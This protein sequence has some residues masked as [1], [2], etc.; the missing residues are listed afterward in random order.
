MAHLLAAQ[1]IWLQRCKKQPAAGDALWPDWKA[2]T[3]KK[4]IEDNHAAWIGFLEDLKDNDFAESIIYKNSKGQTFT[5]RLDD[6]LAHLI[7]H[8]THHRAQ[9]G[10][11]L[12][13]AGTQLPVSDYIY[14]LRRM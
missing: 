13:L 6:V 5:N 7:N 12:K 3:F 14:Y 11:H 9:A 2:D 4:I 8:G 1:Q 10:Q